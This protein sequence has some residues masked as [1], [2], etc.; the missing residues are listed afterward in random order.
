MRKGPLILAAATFTLE[1]VTSPPAPEV[2]SAVGCETDGQCPA[3]K[4]CAHDI[5]GG[6]CLIS[7]DVK[8][9][10]GHDPR[11]PPGFTCRRE[12][13][14]LAGNVC[15]EGEDFSRRYSRV[16]DRY[17]RDHDAGTGRGVRILVIDGDEVIE[18]QQ[19]DTN[20]FLRDW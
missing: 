13:D 5:G 8:V 14:H 17:L 7:C 2:A 16:T 15:R 4:A 6:H 12:Y 3:G 1:C 19:V 18:Y 20:A 9:A 11:C 10:Q